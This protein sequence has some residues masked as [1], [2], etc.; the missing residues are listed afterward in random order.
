MSRA[1]LIS[2]RLHEGRYHGAG[3]WPPAPAR[4]FQALVAGAGLGGPLGKE[5][6]EALGWLERRAPPLIGVPVMRAGQPVMFYMPN[7]DLDAVGGNPRRIAEIRTATK[8]FRPLLFDATIPFLYAW[9]LDAVEENEPNSRVVCSL[10]E[11]L[12]Q[13]GRGVDMAWAWGEMLD[14]GEFDALLLSYAGRVYRPSS[15]GNGNTLACPEP[16]SLASLETRYRANGRRFKTESKGK[17]VKQI[18]SQAPRPRFRPVA[19]ESTPSRRLYELR[20][21]TVDDAAYGVWPLAQASGLVVALRDRAVERLRR[22]L[23]D[24]GSEIERVLVG[25]KPDGSDDG[26]TSSRVK[27]VP[28]PSIG[29]HHADRGIRRILVEIPAACPLRSS[30][31]HWAFSGLELSEPDTGELLDQVLIPAGDESMLDHYGAA[32]ELRCRVW[33]TVTPCALPEASKRRRIDPVRIAIEAKDGV[34]RAAEQ[35]RAAAAVVS[36]LRHAEVRGRAE[37]IRV[38]REPFEAQGERV[39]AFAPGTR[40]G[41]E[42]LWHVEI[43]FEA[44][45]AGPLIIGDGRFL[46]LGLM[47]P[48]RRSEGVCAFVV[49]HG[50]AAR[51]QPAEV[52]RSLRRA[53]M[54]RVQDVLGRR[55]ALPSFFTGHERGGSPAQ[56]EDPHLTFAFDPSTARLIVVAPHVVDRRTPTR[57]EASA[58]EALD[59]SLADFRELRAGSSG[60]LTLRPYVIDAGMDRLFAPSRVWESVTPYQVTRHAK[61]VGAAE[62][63]S[64]DLLV[65]C[66][67]RG[68]P[69]PRVAPRDLRGVPGVGLIGRARL[70][71][72]VAVQGPIIL[73]RTRHRGGG[74]FIG[75]EPGRMSHGG[76]T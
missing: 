27:I 50:L 21:S 32:A 46:G 23:P 49:E 7:N 2:V 11:R 56:S 29:H 74:L 58:L 42:R 64:A 53:V 31:V 9:S 18:F 55:T 69:E 72:E 44:P 63:L 1:L 59:A 19:Y 10:S 52:A 12:Y 35:C 36:A 70:S 24:R 14:A 40:F 73:G 38:Q 57:E 17:T 25:R 75:T 43:T 61:G 8:F 66:R 37:S 45:M 48:V 41:K 20:D 67:R 34:E 76:G 33:R 62:V 13:L 28:L 3:D 60:K 71:F 4:L 39:E 30:D 51:P 22:A 16:G 68:L 15:G 5:V 26:P 6:S 65:E 47:A 54:A